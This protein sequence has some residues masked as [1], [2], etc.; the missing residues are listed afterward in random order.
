MRDELQDL[1]KQNEELKQDIRD[2]KQEISTERR[3][4]EKVFAYIF[5]SLIKVEKKNL[6]FTG[7]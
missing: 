6:Q 4:A 3:T 7:I 2:L 1:D 5:S